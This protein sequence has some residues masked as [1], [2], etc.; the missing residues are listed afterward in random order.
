MTDAYGTT[1]ALLVK[2]V[3]V[4]EIRA[5]DVLVRV[6]AAGIGWEPGTS[7]PGARI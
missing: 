5:D 6:R 1:D 7:R 2:R 3:P 4:P